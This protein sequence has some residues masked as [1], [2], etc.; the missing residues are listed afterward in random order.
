MALKQALKRGDWI[1]ATSL[2][3]PGATLTGQAGH[4]MN[5][6]GYASLDV[7]LGP[8]IDYVSINVNYWD[9]EVT[10]ANMLSNNYPNE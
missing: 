1:K 9:V 3:N 10:H 4:D 7:I 8:N 6:I 5:R 2:E